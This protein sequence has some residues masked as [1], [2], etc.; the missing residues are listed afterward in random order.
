[1]KK[2]LFIVLI[3]LAMPVYATTTDIVSE[4]STSSV[5]Q[6]ITIDFTTPVNGEINYT[7]GTFVHD[8]KVTNGSDTL[9]HKLINDNGVEILSIQSAR[10]SRLVIDYTIPDVVFHSEN[11]YHFFTELSFNSSTLSARARLPAGYGLYDNN[12]KPDGADI[13]SDGQRIILL[14]SSLPQDTFFSIK[15]VQLNSGSAVIPY[16]AGILTITLV[17][18]FIYYKHKMKQEFTKG[19]RDDERKVVEYMQKNPYAVQRD[20]QKMFAFSRA[21]ATR[22]VYALEKRGLLRKKRYG[23]TNKLYW[24][25]K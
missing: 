3:A 8:V 25:K 2:A 4:L 18:F 20:V 19:F 11:V 24:T 13:V 10:T 15:F 1:M 17:V 21:K 16:L 14:W 6:T 7:L 23:R 22:I 5:H 9:K 12:Y